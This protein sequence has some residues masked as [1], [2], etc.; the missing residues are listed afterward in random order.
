MRES[1]NRLLCLGIMGVYLITTTSNHA[2]NNSNSNKDTTT[3]Q[4]EWALGCSAMLIERNHDR[5]DLLGTAVRSERNI[6]KMKEFLI[7]SGWDI[8]NRI[9]L[10]ENLEWIEKGGH[11]SKFDGMGKYLQ[12][13]NPQEYKKVLKDYE[14]NPNAQHKFKITKEYYR[15][16][17]RKSLLG[18]DYSRYICICRWG[19]MAGYLS[20]EEAWKRIMPVAKMLQKTFSSWEDLGKNYIIGRQFWSYKATQEAGYLF[21]DAYQRLLDMPTSPWNKYPW[22]MDLSDSGVVD[23]H[24][25]PDETKTSEEK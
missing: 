8:N 5:H 12:T 14:K 19:Y 25:I 15:K 24:K 7:T 2:Q 18:W 6:E 23:K 20:E 16:L 17:G 13:L 10:L 11:R 22:T 1:G 9:D 4:R 3:K 21:D